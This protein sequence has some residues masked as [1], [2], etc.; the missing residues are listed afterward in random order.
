MELIR[1]KADSGVSIYVNPASVAAVTEGRGGAPVT[2]TL[3]TGDVI[4][5]ETADVRAVAARLGADVSGEA[6]G[7]QIVFEGDD[8]GHVQ[9]ADEE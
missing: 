6:P 7:S 8:E 2:V 4:T 3:T 5:L 1:L 9:L